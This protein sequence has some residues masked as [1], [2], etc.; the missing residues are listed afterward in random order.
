[1]EK[2]VSV[3]CNKAEMLNC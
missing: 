2:S 3:G 1:M